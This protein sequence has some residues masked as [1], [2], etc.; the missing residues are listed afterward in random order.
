MQFVRLVRASRAWA[1]LAIPMIV[2]CG[3]SPSDQASSNA[4]P[5]A[6]TM[7]AELPNDESSAGNGTDMPTVNPQRHPELWKR[8]TTALPEDPTTPADPS[9]PT[10]P[11]D[12]APA[13]A[14]TTP[15]PTNPTTPAPTPSTPPSMVNVPFRG[16]N[17]AGGEFGSALPG[18]YGSDYTFPTPSE[19]D[20]FMGKGMN[21][22][23]V[24]FKWERLQGSAYAAFD[25]TYASRLESIV[26]YATSKGAK[27]ILN[28]HNF[29]RYYGSTVGS[30]QVPN[31][32]FADLWSR[33]ATKYGP[34]ANVMF[35]LVNEPHDMSTEQWVGAANAAIAAI[36]KAGATNTIIVPG[37]AWTGAHSWSSSGYGTPN[38]VAMLNIADPGDNVLF[39]VHQYLDSD[40]SGSSGTCVSTT[41]GAER[42]QNF[43]KWLR[44]HGKKGF[45]G[46]FA[47]GNNATCNTA[48][49]GMLD[50]V[51]A[52]SDVI[53]GWT[54][55]AGGPWWGDYVFT[56]DPKN[57]AD[58]PQMALITPYLAK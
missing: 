46:E 2:A 4:P 48:V 18:S 47:G 5:S 37:N 53:V 40:S 30:S 39:E 15:T 43:I 51:H 10:P 44:D 45:L 52:S 21:T 33:L 29:A 28:P 11:A 34:N 14:P 23:R 22:F 19:V 31:G 17:L 13:P 20:Y 27:V 55:W 54:W 58:R 3:V 56:L 9:T 50:L 6:D 41:I 36:R 24:G 35:N 38:S 26:T 8:P 25:A 57:G 1:A 32:V 16:V 42:M 7:G 12:P 49:K